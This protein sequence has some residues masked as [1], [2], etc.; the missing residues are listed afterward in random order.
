MTTDELIQERHETHGDFKDNARLSQYLKEL[1]R[2]E[3]GWALLGT[4]RREALDMIALKISRILS[5]KADESDHWDDI[6]GY[7]R[8]AAAGGHVKNMD[9]YWKAKSLDEE[10]EALGTNRTD[11]ARVDAPC[12]APVRTKRRVDLRDGSY[13]YV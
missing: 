6:A 10:R 1:F 7:A 13:A 9:K 12:S 5:G 4:V 8:L 11:S 2:D 3:E